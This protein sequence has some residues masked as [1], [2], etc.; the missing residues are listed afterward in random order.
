MAR[1]F[2]LGEFIGGGGGEHRIKFHKFKDAIKI[3]WNVG[4]SRR[5]PRTDTNLQNLK[6]DFSRALNGDIDSLKRVK[7]YTL[8]RK[9]QLKES[10][11]KEEFH[12][13][14]DADFI[15]Q[16]LIV[17]DE[18]SP[19][20]NVFDPQKGIPIK[21]I[22][23]TGSVL[24]SKPK[25]SV[26]ERNELYILSVI[27]YDL[28][29][30]EDSQRSPIHVSK[31][32]PGIENILALMQDILQLPKKIVKSLEDRA[33]QG[34]EY[35]FNLNVNLLRAQNTKITNAEFNPTAELYCRVGYMSKEAVE[36]KKF[37]LEGKGIYV[38][39]TQS[40]T[41]S[42]NPVW[43]QQYKLPL[44][45]KMDYLSIEL[46]RSKAKKKNAKSSDEYLCRCLIRLDAHMEEVNEQLFD[47]L[48]SSGKVTQWKICLSIK[49]IASVRQLSSIAKYDVTQ[50]LEIYRSFIRE[51][52]Q[53]LHTNQ[54]SLCFDKYVQPFE[55][56]RNKLVEML[57]LNNFQVRAIAFECAE[58]WSKSKRLSHEEVEMCIGMLNSFWEKTENILSGD[59][60]T[61]LIKQICNLLEQEMKR[62][63]YLL[64]EFPPTHLESLQSVQTLISI[65]FGTYTFLLNRTS[66]EF[67][68]N[69]DTNYDI[70]NDVTKRLMKGINTWYK[71]TSQAVMVRI[72][73]KTQLESL[74]LL[75]D[76][77]LLLMGTSDRSYK[78]A[79]SA[80]NIDF[81][82]L[83]IFTIDKPLSKEI[84][85]TA[86]LILT[87]DPKYGEDHNQ[88]YF[89]SFLLYRK[90]ALI[91]KKIALS[92]SAV[93]SFKLSSHH[94]WFRPFLN[95]WVVALREVS[96]KNLQTTIEI[97]SNETHVYRGI[98]CNSSVID[99]ALCLLPSYLF[100]NKLEG[101]VD[102]QDIFYIA[103]QI[104]QLNVDALLTYDQKMS[105][106]ACNL[107]NG[108]HS[109]ELTTELCVLLNNCFCTRH[110]R[111]EIT[112]RMHLEKLKSLLEVEVE[113]KAID[114]LLNG[115]LDNIE[116]TERE[117]MRTI[118]KFFKI[119]F[120]VFY[121][122]FIST[123]Q[124][125]EDAIDSLM[126]WLLT[127]INVAN[128]DLSPGLFIP[129]LE[130]MWRRTLECIAEYKDPIRS[131][132][133]SNKI[134]ESL[135][136][137]YQFFDND[138][139]G[140]GT[141]QTD[142]T[143][144]D[145][146]IEHFSLYL[147]DSHELMLMFG[148]D[149]AEFCRY[150]PMKRGG[151]NYSVAY[152]IDKEILE[153]NIIQIANIPSPNTSG[154]VSL[155]LQATVL[156]KYLETKAF[157]YKTELKK[158]EESMVIDESISIPVA[159]VAVPQGYLLQISLYY[160]SS[161]KM[162]LYS[163]YGGSIFL[164]SDYVGQMKST[165]SLVDLLSGKNEVR[166]PI[167]MSFVDPGE[168]EILG[169]LR[170]RRHE[171]AVIN[172]FIES[173]TKGVKEGNAHRKVSESV[174]GTKKFFNK[175]LK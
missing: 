46:W 159:K 121:T 45:S 96:M 120:S 72:T 59:Q 21:K 20:A 3:K 58:L 18:I 116:T 13:L 110:Y 22:D 145:S 77:V 34:S 104:M 32:E 138:G 170:E 69:Y 25:L 130:E 136:I 160:R 131:K 78:D 10:V 163:E 128:Q 14:Q 56:T 49:I 132:G 12:Y 92:K 33:H 98:K 24:E 80:A 107:V 175:F 28:I 16:I 101:W 26:N 133:N 73:H 40:V 119:Q 124:L 134:L 75:C 164:T 61:R 79:I 165:G 67:M 29:S 71:D 43:E 27:A 64:I 172:T 5:K 54:Y 140:I 153:V 88:L 123:P 94:D 97:E 144:Y 70:N 151:C 17:C 87:E 99:I 83:I 74:V 84:E 86:K 111:E 93:E 52:T 146:L 106:R 82:N 156:P 115:C 31:A 89:M 150:A 122:E 50:K 174:E 53:H 168:S 114:Q 7:E 90:V 141:E 57:E 19:A 23:S 51:L 100:Y 135:V 42:H 66:L 143:I 154:S 129:L 108:L 139:Q 63:E 117:N 4:N 162:G 15:H 44:L 113:R 65:I 126:K 167:K 137:L 37:D 81:S 161:H 47:L 95:H 112:E 30:L 173:V 147:Q 91:M 8:K 103:L 76:S 125:A 36:Q 60:R 11:P 9:L 169:I 102:I 155:Y 171:D 41:E 2:S 127:I 62:L 35:G 39:V 68:T 152:L 85:E 157:E 109:F 148:R 55:R 166:K 149:V 142:G 38:Q 158:Y 6:D 1:K 48:S 118:G 105:A